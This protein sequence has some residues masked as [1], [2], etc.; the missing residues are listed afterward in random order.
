MGT[1]AARER[2]AALA[3]K[4]PKFSAIDRVIGR[5][6]L[7]VGSLPEHQNHCLTFLLF[8]LSVF[9]AAA[10]AMATAL[11]VSGGDFAPG[12]KSYVQAE[13]PA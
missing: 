6:G 10:L 8:K 2:V 5:N 9:D 1:A 3:A 12:V 7:K 4:S 13:M 11:H